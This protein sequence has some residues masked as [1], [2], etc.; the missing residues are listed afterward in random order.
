MCES[1]MCERASSD[2]NLL[3]EVGEGSEP[4]DQSASE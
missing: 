3:T 1:F 4:K 2:W